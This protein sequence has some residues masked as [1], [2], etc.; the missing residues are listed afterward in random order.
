MTD[1]YTPTTDKVRHAY[2]NWFGSS[3]E[4]V[5]LLMGSAFD[6]WLAA[7]DADIRAE[8]DSLA[9]LHEVATERTVQLAAV[10]EEALALLPTQPWRTHDIGDAYMVDNVDEARAML[11]TADTSSALREVR[12]EEWD[13]GWDACANWWGINHHGRVRDKS[14]PHREEGA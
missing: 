11:R 2:V 12:A 6:R 9:R 4:R 1:E 7:H 8:R 5:R 3:A 13:E 10:I 14:N